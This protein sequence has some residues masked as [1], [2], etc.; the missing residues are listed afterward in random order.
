M[1]SS[2]AVASLI[3]V[4]HRRRR[5][6]R[7]AL[8]RVQ[9]D[10]GV[11]PGQHL[12]GVG[13]SGEQEDPADPVAGRAPR[14]E[15]ADRGERQREQ[16]E[17]RAARA[18]EDVARRHAPRPDHHQDERRQAQRDAHAPQRGG[19]PARRRGGSVHR[20]AFSR[21]DAVRPSAPALHRR[22]VPAL[23]SLARCRR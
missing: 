8:A 4:D 16:H 20:H 3:T 22:S 15:R 2:P 19:G 21:R 7:E 10:V 5:R 12:H 18:G 23:R 1:P 6:A 17:R 14:D 9:A 13:Q 11:A